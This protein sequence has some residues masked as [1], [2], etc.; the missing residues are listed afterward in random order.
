VQSRITRADIADVAL[1]MLHVDGVE[2]DD[3]DVQAD[4]SFGKTVAVI[5]RLCVVEGGEEGLNSFLVGVLGAGEI[6][7]DIP[8]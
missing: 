6:D 2:A 1:E 3:G 7:S 8:V 4:I 5:V